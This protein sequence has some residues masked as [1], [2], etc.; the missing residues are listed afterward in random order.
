MS[1]RLVNQEHIRRSCERGGNPRALHLSC[2]QACHGIVRTV[3]YVCA[4][5]RIADTLL[6]ADGERPLPKTPALREPVAREIERREIARRI[7]RRRYE[8]DS[9]VAADATVCRRLRTS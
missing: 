5:E 8:R 6:L 4:H 7:A 1:R 3:S 2:T 9:S